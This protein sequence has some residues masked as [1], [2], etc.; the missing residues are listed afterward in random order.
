MLQLRE[1]CNVIEGISSPFDE[2]KNV[3]IERKGFHFWIGFRYNPPRYNTLDLT[4]KVDEILV[5]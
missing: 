2:A 5:K 3:E 1:Y 4:E